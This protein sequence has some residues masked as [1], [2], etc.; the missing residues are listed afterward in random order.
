MSKTFAGLMAGVMGAGTG[1][2]IGSSL[3]EGRNAERIGEARANVDRAN[4]EA[5]MRL[6]EEEAKIK[7]EEGRRLLATQKASFA[8]GNVRVDVGSPLV[9]A[10]Q[11]RADILKDVGFIL[12]RGE[13][14]RQGYLNQANLE[15]FQG[16]L[17]KK[18]SMWDAIS[19][20]LS[21]GTNIAML[22]GQAGLWGQGKNVAPLGYIPEGMR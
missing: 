10:A 4:A 5:A 15:R 12:E 9:V 14:Q 18:R 7:L 13:V 1:L 8:A 17:I 16:K 2:Q 20:G 21:G 11:T 6:A 22:G 19:A 3:A